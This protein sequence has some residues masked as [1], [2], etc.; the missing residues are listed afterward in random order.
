MKKESQIIK[1]VTM[2]LVPNEEVPEYLC[3]WDG[4]E[5]EDKNHLTG[6]NLDRICRHGLVYM[7]ED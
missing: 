7:E 2:E 3:L 1:M 6:Y 5:E 4:I